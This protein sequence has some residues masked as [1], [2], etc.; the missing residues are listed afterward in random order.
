MPCECQLSFLLSNSEF[1]S[2]SCSFLRFN[3]RNT[4]VEPLVRKP[5]A[6]S[7]GEQCDEASLPTIVLVEIRCFYR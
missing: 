3:H 1:H 2:G 4:N 5:S 6:L 7:C